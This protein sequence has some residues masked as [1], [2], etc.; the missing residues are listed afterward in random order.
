MNLKYKVLGL[1]GAVGMALSITGPAMAATEVGTIDVS[2]TVEEAG[3]GTITIGITDSEGFAFGN[4]PVDAP[5]DPNTG[6]VSAGTASLTIGI[7]GD[8]KLYRDGGEIDIKLGDGTDAGAFL[9]YTDA[10]PTFLGANQA[11]FQI[12]GRYLSIAGL[13]NPQQLKWTGGLN[14]DGSHIWS[15]EN[16][17]VGRVPRAAGDADHGLP[18]YKVGDV[19]GSFNGCN[20]TVGDTV[21]PWDSNCGD[22][23]FGEGSA[24]KQIAGIY[25]GS[26]FV[27]CSQE[28][29]LALNV[30]A[31]VYPGQYQGTLTV[32]QTFSEIP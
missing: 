4:V 32:E 29:Q 27:T 1:M 14:S 25:P 19:Y 11:N 8:D 3:T 2:L 17:L 26:G 24:T 21:T 22:A 28:V 6:L 20:V 7:T 12:P 10:D 16:N 5:G 31:G 13:Q 15:G 9:D 30:P 18:I 23:S